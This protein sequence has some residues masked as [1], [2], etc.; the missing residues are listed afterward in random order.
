M[1][2][3]FKPLCLTLMLSTA[4][5][6]F[7]AGGGEMP[8]RPMGGS[9]T[10]APSPEEQARSA[11]NA[12]VKV[13]EKADQLAADASHQADAKK[14]AKAL[15][16]ANDGYASALKKFTRATELYPSMHEAWNY[17]GYTNRKLGKYDAALAA[18]DRALTL[19]P[20]YPEAIEYRGHAYLGLNRLDDAKAAYLSLFSS[21]RKLAAQ[22][23]AGMQSWVGEHRGNPAGVD[24]ASLESFASW[25]SER[26]AIASQTA[27][28]TREG[29]SAAW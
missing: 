2:N 9:S 4:C 16:K 24:G 17:V 6:A 18:Y 12:G 5:T 19:K 29:A 23:L 21:N 20:G 27:G 11:Y 14:Q 7:G 26:S 13:V 25:V 8:S 1:R 22:L 3:V 28:L 10:P 15:D